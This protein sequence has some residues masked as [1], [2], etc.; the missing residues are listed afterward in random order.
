MCYRS[1][2]SAKHH[3]AILMFTTPASRV[4]QLE[5]ELVSAKADLIGSKTLRTTLGAKVTNWVTAMASFVV[6]LAMTVTTFVTALVGSVE[7]V[8]EIIIT[9]AT[10]IEF[11][12]VTIVMMCEVLFVACATLCAIV[13]TLLD[14]KPKVDTKQVLF[15]LP[16]PPPSPELSPPP[17]PPD[18][19][20]HTSMIPWT[21]DVCKE[22]TSNWQCTPYSSKE[23]KRLARITRRALRSLRV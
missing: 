5:R 11:A 10:W 12:L 8:S 4:L 7:L 15:D 18:S 19:P 14:P 23:E 6:L 22:A 2:G 16:P 9:L 13:S 17:S 20:S 21:L 3:C 1:F